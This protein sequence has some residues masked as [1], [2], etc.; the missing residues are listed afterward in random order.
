MIPLTNM[1]SQ[2]EVSLGLTSPAPFD[3]VQRH[4][5]DEVEPDRPS[6]P[7]FLGSRSERE[8]RVYGLRFP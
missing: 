1:G 5:Y 2:H 4:S 6:N 3:T 7:M 8:M